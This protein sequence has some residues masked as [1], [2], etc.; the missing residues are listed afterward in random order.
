[1]TDQLLIV[2]GVLATAVGLFALGRPRADI[3]AI[4]VAVA[5]TLSHRVN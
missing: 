1:M 4:R 2:F 3:V 5:L